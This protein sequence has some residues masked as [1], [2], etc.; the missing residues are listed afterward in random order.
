M[1]LIATRDCFAYD[2]VVKETLVDYELNYL[3]SEPEKKRSAVI[4]REYYF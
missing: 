4:R 3:Q 2:L 1:G